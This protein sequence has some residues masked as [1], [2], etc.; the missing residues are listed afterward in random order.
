MSRS[1]DRL[2]GAPLETL[3]YLK[4]DALNALHG[5][6]PSIAIDLAAQNL[7]AQIN[8]VEVQK[9]SAPHSDVQEKIED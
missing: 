5:E 6:E 1:L 9:R 3:E 8:A 4:Q 2:K 7:L